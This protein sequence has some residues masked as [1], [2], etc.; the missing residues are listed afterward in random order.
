MFYWW[1]RQWMADFI[2]IIFLNFLMAEAITWL[3]IWVII[4]NTHKLDVL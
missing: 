4:M 1:I 3:K 2:I